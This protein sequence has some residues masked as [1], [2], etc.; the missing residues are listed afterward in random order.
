MTSN[1]ECNIEYIPY[2]EIVKQKVLE[3]Y[4][5]NKEKNKIKKYI[6]I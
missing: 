3:Y 1:C 4:H 5:K 6:Y 2:K